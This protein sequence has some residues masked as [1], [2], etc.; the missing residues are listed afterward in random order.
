M[1][2]F[3]LTLGTLV[4]AIFSCW[5]IFQGIS[6]IIKS[7]LAAS[8]YH[9]FV[10]APIML[11]LTVTFDHINAQLH[12]EYRRFRKSLARKKGAQLDIYSPNSNEVDNTP[13]EDDSSHMR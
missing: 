12:S 6:S 1:R 8:L 11:S 4:T 9:L 3:I 13:W 5:E 7:E 2:Q 10:A